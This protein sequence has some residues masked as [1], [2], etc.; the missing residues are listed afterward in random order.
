MGMSYVGRGVGELLEYH[1]APA[2]SH[3]TRGEINRVISCLLLYIFR[4]LLLCCPSNKQ[5][6]CASNLAKYD[7]FFFLSSRWKVVLDY[8][9]VQM[10]YLTSC[11]KHLLVCIMAFLIIPTICITLL[12]L[13]LGALSVL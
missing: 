4:A 1:R 13:G 12:G 6:M 8:L 11:C 3:Y 10:P 7:L 9:C 2:Y 5:C